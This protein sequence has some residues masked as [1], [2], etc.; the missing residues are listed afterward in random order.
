MTIA[1]IRG[2]ISEIGVNLSERMEYL[3]T[4][5]TFG[6]MRYGETFYCDIS[7]QYEGLF[8][9]LKKLRKKKGWTQEDITRE[10]HGSLST[11]LLSVE[12]LNTST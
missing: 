11:T 1:E 6:C 7:G 10:I 4:S 5:D 2:K 9:K 8:E 12:P 3:L